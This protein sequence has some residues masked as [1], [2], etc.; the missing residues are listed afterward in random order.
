MRL[1]INLASQPYEDARRFITT[2][3]SVLVPLVLLVIALSIGAGRQWLQYRQLSNE[4]DREKKILADLDVKQAQGMAILNDPA[5]HDVREK[6]AFINGLILRKEISWTRI[7]TDL[8]Q[9]MPAHLRV[10][11]IAP[12]V[13]EDQIVVVMQLGGDSR[14]RAAELVRRMERS[15]VFRGAQIDTENDAAG[16][17]GTQDPMHFQLRA[18]YVPGELA[19]PANES[20]KP[21][22]AQATGGL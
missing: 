22:T 11:S 6:S 15:H 4:V 19:K 16:Q 9:I 2:W 12:E 13:K 8:E 20:E 3:A 1:N 18:E 14:D 10:L 17:A 21:E 7:F 5:N